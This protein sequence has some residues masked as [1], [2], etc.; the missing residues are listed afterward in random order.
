MFAACVALVLAS[1][2]RAA[3]PTEIKIGYLRIPESRAAIS[4]LDVPPDNDGV[5]GAQ[6]AIRNSCWLPGTSSNVTR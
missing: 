5:A 1:G 3:E 6:L 4:L 2:V